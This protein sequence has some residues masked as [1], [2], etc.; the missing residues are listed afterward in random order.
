MVRKLRKRNNWNIL[1]L[2]NKLKYSKSMISHI[3]IG[4]REPSLDRI[5]LIAKTFNV[6]VDTLL[7]ID[8]AERDYDVLMVENKR[9][10]KIISD[11]GMRVKERM[12]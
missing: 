8:S 12:R 7:G 5:V 9:L 10:N 2:A 4:D 1:E 11:I 6:S 3:E